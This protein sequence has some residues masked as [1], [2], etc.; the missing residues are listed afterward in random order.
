ME[1]FRSK[2]PL[3]KGLRMQNLKSPRTVGQE[4]EKLAHFDFITFLLFG[5]NQRMHIFGPFFEHRGLRIG[6]NF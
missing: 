4:K 3:A 2:K 1:F 6:P 5:K